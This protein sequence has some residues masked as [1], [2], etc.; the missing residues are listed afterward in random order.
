MLDNL[1]TKEEVQ[2]I[3]SIPL[4]HTNQRD[5]LIW[6]GTA[7]GLFSVRSAYFIQQ[8]LIAQP[9]VAYSFGAGRTEVWRNIWALSIPNVEKNFLWRAC[10]DLLPTRAN[11][12]R[13][14]VITDPSCIFCGAKAEIGFHICGTAP[15]QGMFGV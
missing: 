3:Q 2:L 14:R 12:F 13:R 1:F 9:L 6:R 8:E 7:N 4:S 5:M 10:R 11:L 15:Q